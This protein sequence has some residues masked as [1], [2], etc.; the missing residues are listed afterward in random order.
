M[1]S[2]KSI[3]ELEPTVDSVFDTLMKFEEEYS[4]KFN[5]LSTPGYYFACEAVEKATALD[6]KM[7]VLNKEDKI[8]LSKRVDEYVSNNDDYHTQISK[9]F[10]EALHLILKDRPKSMTLRK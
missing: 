3:K 9:T 4:I 6:F 5:D 1:I 2:L 10:S 7:S 8:E